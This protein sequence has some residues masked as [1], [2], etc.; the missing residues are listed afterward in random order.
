MGDFT[1]IIVAARRYASRRTSSNSNTGV[2]MD[3]G[4]ST[5][6][7]GW[8]IAESKRKKGKYKVTSE[9]I[10]LNDRES[11]EERRQL[12]AVCL[13]SLATKILKFY[14]VH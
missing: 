2:S 9:T 11:V 6:D 8:K 13:H 10:T 5:P 4:E 14:H 7:L 1:D 3:T 12:A